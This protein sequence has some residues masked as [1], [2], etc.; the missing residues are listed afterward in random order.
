MDTIWSERW[1]FGPSEKLLFWFIILSY[2]ILRYRVYKVGTIG[3][4]R[5]CCNNGLSGTCNPSHYRGNYCT[6]LDT[7]VGVIV[8]L[9]MTYFWHISYILNHT[10]NC[11]RFLVSNFY[12]VDWSPIKYI[13]KFY[14]LWG[15]CHCLHTFSTIE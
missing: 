10:L 14:P 9:T 11:V 15:V 1:Y 7:L 12:H 4:G 3:M 5:L 8:C 13:K 6:G 2:N